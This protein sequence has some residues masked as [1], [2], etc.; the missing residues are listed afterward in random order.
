VIFFTHPTAFEELEAAKTRIRKLWLP[1]AEI[2]IE[3]WARSNRVLPSDSGRPGEWRADPIQREIQESIANPSVREVVFMKSTRLGWSEI[4]NNALGWGVDVHKMA[5]LMA[6]PSRETAESYCKE[7]LDQ[8]IESTPALMALLRQSTSKGAG[9]T[10]RYKRF[11]NGASFFVASAANGREMRSRRSR[12]IILDEVDGYLTLAEGSAEAIIKKRMEEYGADARMLMGS[13]PALPS[14]ISL[15]E[16]AYNRSSMGLYL[17]PCPKC[18]AMEPFLWRNPANPKDYLLKFERDKD[19]QVISDSVHWTCIR[20]GEKIPE[21]WKIRMMEAGHWHHRRPA[22]QQVK[23]YWANGLYA[24][25]DGHWAQMAQTFTNAADDPGELRTFVNLDLAETYNDPGES[26]DPEEL[27]KRADKEV[28]DR[29]IVPD[30]VAIIIVTVDLQTAGLGRLEAQAVGIKPDERAYLIDVQVFPGDPKQDAVYEDLDA[31]LLRGWKHQNGAQMTPHLVFLDARDGNTRDAVYNFC[32]PRADRWIFPQMGV[33]V[34][35]SKGWCEESTNRKQVGRM[36]LTATDDTKRALMSRLAMPD[37]NAP[38][39][40][41][42]PSWVSKEYLEQLSGEKRMPVVDP[43]TRKTSYR[44]VKTRP[45]NEGLDLW[46][47]ALSGWWAI[48]RILAPHLGG[49]D[50]RAHLEDL[51]AQA[52]LAREQVVYTETSGRR[53]LSKGIF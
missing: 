35:A 31:W 43:K 44:W 18:N 36:F 52:S 10:T 4:C 24:V 47:Y 16:K 26:S 8:M 29:A 14:G 13:T 48:T 2:S 15:I 17:V 7:R 12:F 46:S 22:V 25:T 19:N 39:S 5:M 33:D 23:G 41:H 9:S 45:R 21:R 30:G 28:R 11:R 49:P 37:P 38:K 1:P 53:I 42:L 34:L 50:G 6:Q 3:A 27:R 40:I 51:A 20:C 32:S